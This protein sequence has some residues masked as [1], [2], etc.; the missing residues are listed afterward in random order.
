MGNYL[1]IIRQVELAHTHTDQNPTPQPD[2]APDMLPSVSSVA[3]P[4]Q[5]TWRE[6]AALTA[7]LEQDDPRLALVLEALQEAGRSHDMG[8][9][10]GFERA[11]ERT[12]YLMRF[13]PG[14]QVWW[15]GHEGHHLKVLGPATVEHVHAADGRLWVWTA[16]KGQGRWVPESVIA[17]IGRPRQNHPE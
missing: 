11:V 17:T 15:N 5:P 9:E 7:G 4:A 2:P 14:A 12:R 3:T 16:W 1:D 13:V 6:L 8:E 10:P